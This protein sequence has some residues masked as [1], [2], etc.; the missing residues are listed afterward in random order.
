MKR[1]R[2]LYPAVSAIILILDQATKLIVLRTIRPFEEISLLPF[3]QLV[4][5]KNT[6]AAFGLFQSMGNTFFIIVSIIA[7]GVVSFLMLRGKEDRPY[8]SLI[9]GGALGNLIDRLRLGYV[10]DFIDL[11]AGRH[12]WP[13]FNVADSALTAG[14]LLLF[15]RTLIRR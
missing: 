3:L 12:H 11:Y 13:A 6:G 15:V 4:N 9:L 14:I 1:D 8:L 2:I 7:I 5:V 10:V